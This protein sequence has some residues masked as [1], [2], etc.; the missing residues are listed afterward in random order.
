MGSRFDF[1]RLLASPLAYRVL[2]ALTGEAGRSRFVHTHVRPEPGMRILDIG[3]GPGDIL[4]YLPADIEYL[5]F[6]A[7]P[8]Y[9]SAA[10][11]RYGDRAKFFCQVVSAADLR[12]TAGF[13]LVL[14]SGVLH[15]LTDSE[16]IDLFTLAKQALLA[17]G[18]L[19][20]LDGCFAPGQSW[21]ARMMLRMDRGRHVRTQE[22]YVGLA[23]RVFPR[24]SCTVWHD[25]IRLRYTHLVPECSA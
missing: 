11:E 9:I 16:A 25:M 10:R 13:D 23:N 5:G 1:R 8:R 22:G 15:H 2:G 17:R 20:T 19:V 4:A 12:E 14:A 7:S 18:R 6:D 24:V 3:C 21:A